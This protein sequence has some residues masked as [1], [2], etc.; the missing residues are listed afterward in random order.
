MEKR[1]CTTVY[2]KEIMEYNDIKNEE[3]HEEV[4]QRVEQIRNAEPG[5]EEAKELKTLIKMLIEY[6]KQQMHHRNKAFSS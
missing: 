1:G 4:T 6:E 5:T 3:Q 2:K